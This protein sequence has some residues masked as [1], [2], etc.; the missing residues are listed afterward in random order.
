MK[1]VTFS[2]KISADHDIG[3]KFQDIL[4]ILLPFAWMVLILNIVTQQ[5]HMF[6][7]LKNKEFWCKLI[8]VLMGCLIGVQL[9]N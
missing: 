9:R 7:H 3:L 5:W 4:E 2:N 8:F 1:I 6:N